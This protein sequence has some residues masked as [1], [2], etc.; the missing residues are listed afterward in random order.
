MYILMVGVTRH[1]KSAGVGN[2][3]GIIF[4]IAF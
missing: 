3:H 2:P 1:A 4:A